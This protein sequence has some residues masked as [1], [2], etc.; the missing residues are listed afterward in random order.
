MNYTD[1]TERE[2]EI[3]AEFRSMTDEQ[4]DTCLCDLQNMLKK[5]EREPQ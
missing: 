5:K 1:L 2:K 4:Q 3:L